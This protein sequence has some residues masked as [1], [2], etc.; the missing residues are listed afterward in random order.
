[1]KRWLAYRTRFPS[2]QLQSLRGETY[3]NDVSFKKALQ[4]ALGP[5]VAK[6][7]ESELISSA[8]NVN[9]G[10]IL[11]GILSFVACFAVS[12]GPVM[13]VLF[14]EMFPNRIRGLAISFV[15]FINSGVSFLVQLVFPW[16]LANLGSAATFLSFGVFAAFGLIFIV[17]RLPE[18]KGRSLE[19]L[20]A[21]L[22]RKPD[23][24]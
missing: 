23:L 4:H 12:L 21:E 15:G 19:Q 8:I 10:L 9:P 6:K 5:E 7:Y 16:S 24:S 11:L 3:T 13:W 14:S 2:S 18:T 20:E 1:M 17:W 22:V